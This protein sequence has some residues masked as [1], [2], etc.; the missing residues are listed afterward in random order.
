MK[1]EIIDNLVKK[2]SV[3][4]NYATKSS[5][6]IRLKENIDDFRPAFYRDIDKIINYSSYTRYSNKTQVFSFLGNDNVQTR[7][8]HVSLVSKISRT[9]GRAM[10]LNED[11]IEAIALAHDIGHSPI[12]HVGE[13]ILN[14]ISIRELNEVFMH[15]IQGVRN[16]MVL[17][18]DGE[19]S[20]L[21]IQVLD[22]IMCHNGEQLFKV[23]KPRKKTKEEFLE[24]YHNSYHMH[25]KRVDMTPMTL[26]GCIVKISDVISY[27]GRDIE[28]AIRLGFVNRDDLPSNI[29]DVL[30]N[31]NKTIVH[32][33]VTDLITN[34]YD[35]DYLAFSDD[36]FSALKDLFKFNYE[37]IYNIAN[38]KER[39]NYYDK[40]FNS[41]YD[42]YKKDLIN[43]NKDSSI[44]KYHLNK[45]SEEY[46]KD[47]KL[48][49]KIIDY[50]AMMTD[51]FLIKEYEENIL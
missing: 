46:N 23:Y 30:G 43:E 34:S 14:K 20:N 44:Y 38:T 10:C 49:R 32:T 24:D 5:E 51:E 50:L 33:L 26:E 17:E 7:I 40:V 28:D 15:N 18:N 19:G 27:V 11:L 31:S 37:H 16:Y 3:L 47:T 39:L 42:H 22:G 1:Q 9:I 35:K 4:S 2:E 45:M 12:G 41:L 21:S 29:T 6:A 25:E 36:V 13:K 48:E 8:I